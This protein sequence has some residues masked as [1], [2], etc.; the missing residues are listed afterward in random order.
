MMMMMTMMM[1]FFCTNFRGGGRPVGAKA[2]AL[3]AH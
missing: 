2:L 1:I 3:E